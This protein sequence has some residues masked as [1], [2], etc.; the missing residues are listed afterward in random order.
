MLTLSAVWRKVNFNKGKFQCKIPMSEADNWTFRARQCGGEKLVATFIDVDRW[1]FQ[2]GKKQRFSQSCQ[3]Q[4]TVKKFRQSSFSEKSQF[5]GAT[6]GILSTTSCLRVAIPRNFIGQ[7]QLKRRTRG[8]LSLKLTQKESDFLSRLSELHDSKE[9]KNRRPTKAVYG[10]CPFHQRTKGILS[11][12]SS[13]KRH[14]ELPPAFIT[15]D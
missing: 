13:Y 9:K 11:A 1:D 10:N 15:D 12:T 6:Q 8:F 4:V 5:H 7:S 14:G 3:G 2:H